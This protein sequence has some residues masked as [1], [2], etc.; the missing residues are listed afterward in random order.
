MTFFLE[1]Q[2]RLLPAVSVIDAEV[3]LLNVLLVFALKLAG[4]VASI[5]L[6][7]DVECLGLGHAEL[8][9]RLGHHHRVVAHFFRR[10]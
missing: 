10:I 6:L 1:H 7:D 8:F 9:L 5:Q 3:L 2:P 4:M